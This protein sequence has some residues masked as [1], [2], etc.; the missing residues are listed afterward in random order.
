MQS[1]W[2]GHKQYGLEYFEYDGLLDKKIAY[3]QEELELRDTTILT[4]EKNNS[5]KKVSKE[6]IIHFFSKSIWYSLVLLAKNW[7]KFPETDS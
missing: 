5:V 6:A 1:L 3:P 2:I 7:V 4:H